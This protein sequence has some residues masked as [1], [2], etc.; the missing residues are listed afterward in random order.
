MTETI[1]IVGSDN[2]LG[3]AVAEHFAASTI[4]R[5]D[6]QL[7]NIHFLKTRIDAL[8]ETHDT[9]DRLFFCHYEKP[10]SK[11]TLT[12]EQFER[13]FAYNYLSRH[14]ISYGLGARVTQSV[15]SL[16]PHA[17]D[18]TVYIRDLE[19]KDGYKKSKVDTH[20][21]RLLDLWTIHFHE[22]HNV[23]TIGYE[24]GSVKEEAS[25]MTSMFSKSA[26]DALAPLWPLL[27]QQHAVVLATGDTHIDT[28]ARNY[29]PGKAYELF[30]E[31]SRKLVIAQHNRTVLQ[32]KDGQ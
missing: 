18:D 26:A 2:A 19:L 9:I 12:D 17:N 15:V 14:I 16:H 27:A 31:T 8:K 32:A 1:L 10:A 20:I 29:H 6:D 25:F 3:R 5:I 30:M 22:K 28:T 7:H 24:A 13:A 21:Q 4:I 11:L 23:L